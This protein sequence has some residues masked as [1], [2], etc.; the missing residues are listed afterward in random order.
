MPPAPVGQPPPAPFSAGGGGAQAARMPE[1]LE[2]ETAAPP[3]RRRKSRRVVA[4]RRS[5]GCM[6]LSLLNRL[7]SQAR[8]ERRHEL[9]HRVEDDPIQ[10]WIQSGKWLRPVIAICRGHISIHSVESLPPPGPRL[11]SAIR[12]TSLSLA[13]SSSAC[14]LP[15]RPRQRSAGCADHRPWVADPSPRLFVYG[16]SVQKTTGSRLAMS[17]TGP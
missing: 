1:M 15:E 16:P 10:N 9:G 6:K 13:R 3:D 11:A 7:A 2:S 17:R 4:R 14:A 5:F 8:V 12:R